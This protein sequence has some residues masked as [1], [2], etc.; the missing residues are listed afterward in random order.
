MP[1]YNRAIAGKTC[2]GDRQPT[3]QASI[4]IQM[5]EC[6]RMNFAFGQHN[7]TVR[8]CNNSGV[9]YVKF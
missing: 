8:L 2:N 3:Y 7:V 4:C 9:V 5:G 1:G 6:W